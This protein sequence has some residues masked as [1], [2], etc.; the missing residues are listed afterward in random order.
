MLGGLTLRKRVSNRQATQR[1]VQTMMCWRESSLQ[2]PGPLHFHRMVE[3]G[4]DQERCMIVFQD[5]QLK[6]LIMIEYNQVKIQLSLK[7]GIK[8][9]VVFPVLVC[10]W[11]I[12]C[13]PQI[14]GAIHFFGITD[15]LLKG[16]E[17]KAMWW[18]WM[19]DRAQ[20]GS[21]AWISVLL[22][23]DE[24]EILPSRAEDRQGMA[25]WSLEEKEEE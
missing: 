5:Y 10:P 8:K 17:G 22:L 1:G 13:L 24:D 20:P 19:R 3:C 9:V 4:V 12:R 2:G 21:D 25:E 15:G 14:T 11:A 18:W 6:I 7:R 16:E 23:R